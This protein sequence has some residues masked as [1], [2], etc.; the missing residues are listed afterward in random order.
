MGSV[1]RALLGVGLLTA[2]VAR[3]A[4]PA[5]VAPGPSEPA[6]DEPAPPSTEPPAPGLCSASGWCWYHPLPQ[7]NRLDTLLGTTS[8]EVWATGLDTLLRFDGQRWERIAGTPADTWFRQLAPRAS[9]GFWALGQRRHAGGEQ[10]VLYAWDGRE[11]LDSGLRTRAQAAM[12]VASDRDI[13]L[14]TVDGG[15]SRWDGQALRAVDSPTH[16]YTRALAGTSERDVWLAADDGLFHWDGRRWTRSRP[17]SHGVLA[18]GPGDVWSVDDV[19]V[20]HLSGATWRSWSLGPGDGRRVVDGGDG[21][22]WL[23]EER[24]VLRLVGDAWQRTTSEVRRIDAL[25][26]APDG[27]AWALEDRV[28]LM[29]WDGASWTRSTEDAA[30]HELEAIWGADDDDVWAAG[31]RGLVLHFDGRAWTRVPAPDD[32]SIRALWGS[33]PSDVWAVGSGVFHWDGRAW[34]RVPVHAWGGLHA[35]WGTGPSDVWVQGDRV[36]LHFDGCWW[37]VE[38]A[39]ARGYRGYGGST[40]RGETWIPDDSGILRR[41][42]QGWRLEQDLP[43]TRTTLIRGSQQGGLWALGRRAGAPSLFTRAPDEGWRAVPLPP[44]VKVLFDMHVQGRDSVYITDEDGAVYRWDGAAWRDE[45]QDLSRHTPLALWVSPG[46]DQWLSG[47]V[48]GGLLRKRATERTSR[49]D[50]P[51]AALARPVCGPDP[52][53]AALASA[54]ADGAQEGDAPVTAAAAREVARVWLEEMRDMQPLRLARATALPLTVDGFGD[55]GAPRVAR[56]VEEF[57]DLLDCVLGL[58][59]ALAVPR[60]ARGGWSK[61]GPAGELRGTLA[62]IRPAGLARRLSRHRRAVEGLARA[63]QVLVQARIDDRGVIVD[64]AL[65][66]R[67]TPSGP[68][69]T[70]VLFD[71]HFEH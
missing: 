20:H 68:R 67:A 35:V 38:L 40:A 8:A 15:L 23:V 1:S 46:G 21:G 52:T 65:A 27:V 60:D 70:T 58:P 2:C 54:L 7:G 61:R 31:D 26:A 17:A 48:R 16:A 25:W 22:V 13:W 57:R 66:V 39:V 63:G 34:S 4:R 28:V 62:V 51:V 55:C 69:V 53:A 41:G 32:A 12:W 56:D 33:G 9:G 42:D 3:E 30:L 59:Q 29:R 5:E 14:V 24:A 37:S 64:A 19:G 45:A 10:G 6:P 11:W 18:R 43:G 47:G 36:V 49:P 50:P 44:A 71:T